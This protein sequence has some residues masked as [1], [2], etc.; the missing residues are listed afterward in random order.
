[1]T[2]ALLLALCL[3]TTTAHADVWQ[4]AIDTTDSTNDRFEAA[5]RSGDELAQR[6]NA[7]SQNRAIVTSLIDQAIRAYREAAAVVP[8]NAEPYFRIASVLESF[9][10]DCETRSLGAVRPPTCV[11]PPDPVRV[12][13]L[14]AAYDEFEA[15]NPLDPRVA[16]V[17]FSRAISRTKLATDPRNMTM[18]LESALSDY[19][20]MID[21]QDAFSELYER[22][23]GRMRSAWGNHAETLMM[24]GRLEEAVEAYKAALAFGS[25]ASTV[26]G[27]AVAL[28]RDERES[29]ALQLIRA[30]GL[31]SFKDFNDQFAAGEVFFVPKGEEFYY[32][33]LIHEA[34]GYLNEAIANWRLF[35]KSGAHPVYQPRGKAHLDALLI[36]QKTNPRPPP[37][38]DLN[39]Y[40]SP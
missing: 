24:L 26:Y 18:L 33:A 21:R 29:E 11:T 7:K 19:Q 39:D 38:P 12:Q 2:R 5:M 30:Q 1:M 35:I 27:L 40:F 16:D 31:R 3:A 13:E 15:R 4:R 22:M 9:F 20:S 10:T 17:L 34:Y 36:K 14:V 23:Y 28:D 6:A 8:T 37:R 25:N 32:F